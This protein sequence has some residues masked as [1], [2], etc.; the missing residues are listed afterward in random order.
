MKT[1]KSIREN[2][3]YTT[4]AEKDKFTSNDK[5]VINA[6]IFSFVG[7]IGLLDGAKDNTKVKA[8]FRSDQKLRP[9][10]IT[11]ANNDSSLIIKIMKDKGFFKKSTTPN[12][13]TRFLVKVKNGQVNDVDGDIVRGWLADIKDD[14]MKGLSAVVKREVNSF[15]AGG[16]LA[17]LTDNLRANAKVTRWKDTEFGQ[18]SKAVRIDPAK[19]KAAPVPAATAPV[20]KAADTPA[21]AADTIPAAKAAST[22]KPANGQK[23]ADK[24]AAVQGPL[25]ANELYA[26][27]R[28]GEDISGYKKAK[29][30]INTEVSM[31][32]GLDVKDLTLDQ[33]KRLVNYLKNNKFKSTELKNT[34]MQKSYYGGRYKGGTGLSQAIR[35]GILDVIN[36]PAKSAGAI[37]AAITKF[38]EFDNWYATTPTK[39]EKYSS[40]KA[41]W[42]GVANDPELQFFANYVLNASPYLPGFSKSKFVYIAKKD[43]EEALKAFMGGLGVQSLKKV[44]NEY[45]FD[46][47]LYPEHH[48]WW[49]F[50]GAKEASGVLKMA[51]EIV[52][53]GFFSA[54]THYLEAEEIKQMLDILLPA[55]KENYSFINGVVDNSKSAVKDWQKEVV[56]TAIQSSKDTILQ[57]F[58][59][60][61]D[62]Y[63]YKLSKVNDYPDFV[64]KQVEKIIVD[65]PMIKA[66]ALERMLTFG[67]E[68]N[69]K[70]VKDK[71]IK[72][73]A[74][75]VMMY[76]SGMK[77]DSAMRYEYGNPVIK[78]P[79]KN[80]PI[81]SIMNK[82]YKDL[83]NKIDSAGLD[84]VFEIEDNPRF[85]INMYSKMSTENKRKIKLKFE[86]LKNTQFAYGSLFV[87]LRA[88][89]DKEF[90][91]II[92]PKA[93]YEGGGTIS[94]LA[95][96]GSDTTDLMDRFLAL[97]GITEDV[98]R[99]IKRT[100]YDATKIIKI[101]TNSKSIDDQTFSKMVDTA[102]ANTDDSYIG[103]YASAIANKEEMSKKD[104]I[105][106][107][108]TMTWADE[109]VGKLKREYK[110][111]MTHAQPAFVK[112]AQKD[113]K[114]ADAYYQSVSKSMKKRLAGAY[115]NNGEFALT[116]GAALTDASNPIKPFEQL[117]E[118][119]IREILKYNNVTSEETKISDKHT[120]SLDTLDNYIKNEN[121]D[122]LKK[123]NDLQ[124]EEVKKSQKELAQMTA[125][126]HR[127]K[128]SNRHGENS[129]VFKKEF[130][131]A[132]PLQVTSQKEWIE[133]DP[134]Q[135]IIN[136]MY[137]GTGSI[138]ASMI[139]RYGFRVIKSGDS[140]VVGRMLGDGV[141]GA[142]HLDKSQ[143][144]IGDSGYGRRIGTKGYI[145]AMNAAL[146]EKN[147]D[148]Q[149]AGLG[150]RDGIRSPEWCVFTPNSQFK[151][152]KAYEVEL[153][154]GSTM[155]RILAE[156]P[157]N[158]NEDTKRMGFKSYLE[159]MN[160]VNEVYPNYT[161]FTFVNGLIPTGQGSYVD[162]E[163]FKPPKG[164]T[165]EPSAYGPTVVIE[166]TNESGDYIFTGPLDF[167]ENEPEL[168]EEYLDKLQ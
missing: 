36:F 79:E 163:D 134:N 108:K 82:E 168:F 1:F 48:E 41:K 144:Y 38:E 56:I 145:F 80:N 67:D 160:V 146:G 31:F 130:D 133:K 140:S 111:L 77:K 155:A 100:P 150:N 37:A 71:V 18:T 70:D 63:P 118:K 137:H 72:N 20:A 78:S 2:T 7:M 13:I 88:I 83:Q 152:Y 34:L 35:A 95:M 127:T 51:R 136:P 125:D 24:K 104:R 39:S 135:E 27:I 166:G 123:L 86:S 110:E 96:R 159:E 73:Y 66:R 114:A 106:F 117:T 157:V 124:I 26:K 143:Q 162:F 105:L 46:P 14:K 19:K 11:D 40:M 61:Y 42:E 164:V 147:K 116:A 158:T 3:F 92:D 5:L 17:T 8:Y 68:I 167:E 21:P 91:D 154:R 6:F 120:K 55:A 129:M 60:R 44:G 85:P 101:L 94:T 115:I 22:P 131:V 32:F 29:N 141:Y 81:V 58:G 59:N 142:I 75:Q 121:P 119:R 54:D 64:N 52:N 74:Q 153:V 9:D 50:L 30:D 148:Y 65:E 109:N 132:I 87:N 93:Y 113:R 43:K 10:D 84:K 161:T 12:E 23:A 97:P 89:A 98:Q 25:T 126:Y 102:M 33:S 99:D 28:D 4:Q 45:V 57:S 76:I 122:R 90:Y 47:D 62:S 139:L 69:S 16:S 138:A 149:A 151:I 156:N 165:L 128:R 53:T 49:K 103:Y 112:Y 107:E 15:I